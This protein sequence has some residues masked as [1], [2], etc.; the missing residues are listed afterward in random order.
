M[1][2]NDTIMHDIAVISA[3]YLARDAAD[4]MPH[5][6]IGMLLRVSSRRSDG[7]FRAV[8]YDRIGHTTLYHYVYVQIPI[9]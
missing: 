8:S 1:H 7:N 2:W 3:G 6:R 9:G 4:M 5:L